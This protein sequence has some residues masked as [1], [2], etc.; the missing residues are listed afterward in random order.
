VDVAVSAACCQLADDA[1]VHSD[2]QE[3]DCRSCVVM[4]RL[5]ELDSENRS[6]WALHRQLCNRF[7]VDLEAGS[8]AL[9]RLTDG[10]DA[11]AFADTIDRLNVIHD[12]MQP[13]K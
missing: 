8:V 11:E 2:P 7:V 13:K 4:E 5:L 1:T 3:F 12:V 9:D 6:A 10:Q